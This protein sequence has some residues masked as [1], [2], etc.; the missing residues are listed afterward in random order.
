MLIQQILNGGGHAFG[1]L[2]DC[3]LQRGWQGG[4]GDCSIAWATAATSSGNALFSTVELFPELMAVRLSAPGLIRVALVVEGDA[5]AIVIAGFPFA[6]DNNPLVALHR[7]C[8]WDIQS[9]SGNYARST[10]RDVPRTTG[11]QALLQKVAWQ[12]DSRQRLH[13]REDIRAPAPEMQGRE[14]GRGN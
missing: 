13:Q 11:K 6:G 3:A 8:L 12:T 14:G 7:K 5:T 10:T 2:G 1:L 4:G 9:S